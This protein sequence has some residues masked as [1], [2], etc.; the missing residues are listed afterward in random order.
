MK[1]AVF[2]YGVE[3]LSKEKDIRKWADKIGP[4][5]V[6]YVVTFFGW[7]RQEEPAAFVLAVTRSL[8]QA[9]DIARK[10][11]EK[12]NAANEKTGNVVKLWT[13]GRIRVSPVELDRE[14]LEAS[15]WDCP[16]I[17]TIY[18]HVNGT[19]EEDEE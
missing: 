4:D 10:Y 17:G 1:K 11:A 14:T 15:V 18:V 2:P 19:K 3:L 6:V 9:F 16:Y 5:K 12:E 8:P 13:K 7:I